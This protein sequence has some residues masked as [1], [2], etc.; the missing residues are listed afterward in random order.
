MKFNRMNLSDLINFKTTSIEYDLENDLVKEIRLLS[1]DRLVKIKNDYAQLIVL[2]KSPPVYK[3]K[4]I[5]KALD[6]NG[7]LVSKEFASK[8]EANIFVMNTNY[9]DIV[10]ESIKEEMENE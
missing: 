3:E 9:T 10:I 6:E 8:D 4:Y 5:F 1:G 2:E 7:A